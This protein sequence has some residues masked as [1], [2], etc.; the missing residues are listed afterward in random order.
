MPALRCSSS[1]SAVWRRD[2]DF[3]SPPGCSRRSIFWRIFASTL[4]SIRSRA[5]ADLKLL[6]YLGSFPFTGEVHAIAEGTAFFINAPI[7]RVTAPPP[8]A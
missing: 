2:A 8:Q 5:A 3:C 7:L 6:D 1:S 4:K